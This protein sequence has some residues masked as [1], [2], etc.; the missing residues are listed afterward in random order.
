MAAELGKDAF[1][2]QVMALEGRQDS[3]ATLAQL[4]CKTLIIGAEQD[5]LCTP[6]THRDMHR[7]IAGS[8][9]QI[10]KDCG[11]FSVLE[12]GQAVASSLLAWWA[13]EE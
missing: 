5:P 6:D 2:A 4:K 12:K 8:E 13:S 7:L 1:I 9:L 11:H 3:R 10:L